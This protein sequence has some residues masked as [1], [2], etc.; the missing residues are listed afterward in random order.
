MPL[1]LAHPTADT[2]TPTG[3]PGIRDRAYREAAGLSWWWAALVAV[4]VL[5][6]SLLPLNFDSARLATLHVGDVAAMRF[7][8]AGVEDVI[9]NLVVYLPVGFALAATAA[10]RRRSLLIAA[11]AATVLGT[12]VSL[13]AE[14]LQHAVPLRVPSLTDVALNAAGSLAGSLLS[15]GLWPAGRAIVAAA[16]IELRCRPFRSLALALGTALAAWS[17]APFDVLTKPESL[18]RAFRLAEWSA[19]PRDTFSQAWL[20]EL[21][22]ASWFGLWAYFALLGRAEAGDRP[23]LRAAGVLA[24]GAALVIVIEVLQLFVRSHVFELAAIVLRC[25]GVVI[26]V[27]AGVMVANRRQPGAWAERPRIAA[28]T[29]LLLAALGVQIA[30]IWLLAS[31]RTALPSTGT[32]AWAVPFES[33]WRGSMLCAA[34]S[35]MADALRY[36]LMAATLVVVLR[37]AG[38]RT[39]LL[40]GAALAVAA[41]TV[42]V[43]S[44]LPVNGVIDLTVPIL[45]MS[46]AIAATRLYVLLRS[47]RTP[48]PAV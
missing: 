12:L 17:L 21:V 31:P 40:P 30:T 33:L 42:H 6:G 46:S 35:M 44:R 39:L 23:R 3:E 47:G 16:A 37:R 27:L 24:Q 45:A 25:V 7:E 10:L 4:G 41:A 11:M 34:W 43:W 13:M 38:W 8:R 22:E 15:R 48:Q 18:A 14:W 9:T 20:R 29:A 19:L 36:G 32:P 28:P 2:T 1:S 26:G 5:Y